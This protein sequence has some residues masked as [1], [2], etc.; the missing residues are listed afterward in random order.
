MPVYRTPDGKIVE[1]KTVKEDATEHQDMPPPPAGGSEATESEAA[2]GFDAPTKRLDDEPDTAPSDAADADRKLNV[3][4]ALPKPYNIFL[5]GCR[6]KNLGKTCLK[7]QNS[8][9]KPA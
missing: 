8:G 7:M 9:L 4:L 3:F 6:G 5:C 2:A 1:E